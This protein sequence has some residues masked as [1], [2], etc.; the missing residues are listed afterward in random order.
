MKYSRSLAGFFSVLAAACSIVLTAGCG[1]S[2]I[3]DL[4]FSSTVSPVGLTNTQKDALTG[5]FDQMKAVASALSPLSALSSPTVTTPQALVQTSGTA[6]K[7]TATFNNTKTVNVVLDYGATGASVGGAT[8]TG[9][10]TIVFDTAAHT[11]TVTFQNLAENGNPVT[12]TLALTNLQISAQGVSATVTNNLTLATLGTTTGDLALAFS[13]DGGETIAA[14]K[15]TLASAN[16]GTVYTVGIGNVTIN[17]KAN[18]N[19]VPSTGTATIAYPSPDPTTGAASSTTLG[20]TFS[21]QSPVDGTTNLSVNGG[22]AF[23]IKL[24]GVGK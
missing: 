14:T 20:L 2:G 1:G 7:I 23:T 24:T 3:N 12:G 9:A 5:S 8:F 16:S 13:T 19:F 17:P 21:G 10:E 11:G 18:G 4:G 22:T 15:L 6:P